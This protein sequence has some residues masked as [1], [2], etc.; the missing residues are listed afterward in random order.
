[1]KRP[2]DEEAIFVVVGDVMLSRKEPEE[3]F[4]KILG[5]LKSGIFSCCN[6]EGPI[7]NK[8]MPQ[9][10]K[11]STLHAA[12]EMI[13]GF[14]HAGFKVVSLAN[15][16]TMDY[17]A[18]AL[19][20]TIELIKSRGILYA[21]AGRNIEDARR[22]AFF[23]CG[24]T[25]FAFL[26][27]ATE[28]FLGYGAHSHKPGIAMI[29]R[30]PLYGLTCVNPD[31]VEMLTEGIKA[32]RQKADFVIAAFHWGLSQSRA[33]T[34][35]QMALGHAAVDAGASLVVGTHPHVLQA[36][37]AYRGAIILYSLGNFVFDRTSLFLSPESKDTVLV[38]VKL[39]KGVIKEVLLL[40]V[41][42]NEAGQPELLGNEHP[43]N[44]EIL[45]LVSRL[46]SARQTNIRITDGAGHLYPEQ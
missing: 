1:M 34:Q 16:H 33:L 40:P 46:S 21:G 10:G 24:E 27:F 23:D 36:V 25:R 11:Y 20:D 2:G 31:D 43:K 41:F 35:S 39:S 4:A 8:G 12:P 44:N 37:E 28:A 38:K 14:V 18:E 3:A 7:S 22:P 13:E 19:M 6:F 9:Y 15:N 32:A 29:R 17:G 45:R 30:D 26:S 5:E 42:I